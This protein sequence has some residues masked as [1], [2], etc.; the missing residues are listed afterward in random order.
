MKKSIYISSLLALFAAPVFAQDIH[1]SQFYMSPLTLNPAMAGAQ[2]EIQTLFNYKS[3][4]QSVTNPYKTLGFSYDMR[5][6]RKK[7]EK[8]II[9]AGINFFSDRAGDGKMGTTQANLSLS[10]HARLNS[11]NLLGGGLQAGYFQRSL[12]FSALY[13][14]SQYDGTSFNTSY[15]S[16]EP[17]NG[18]SNFS[19]PDF[20]AGIAWTYDN[21]A[22]SNSVTGDN[23]LKFNLGLSAMHVNQPGY[24]FYQAEG[25][26]PMKYTVHGTGLI[27]MKNSNLAFVPGFMYMKQGDAQE[28]YAGTLLRYTMGMDSKYTGFKNGAALSLGGFMRAKDALSAVVMFEYANYSMG[29]SYDIN[30]SG[31]TAAS[32]GRGGIEIALR[33]ISPNPFL[34]KKSV[35][36]FN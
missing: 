30:T 23:D 34:G 27:G 36:S 15:I 31:L 33:F 24:S 35:S 1:F 22:N 7:D 10:Y 28:I 32:N 25:K 21:S 11:D 26:L 8:G 16:G 6:N 3:Q 17:V 9:A 18:T 2:H 5:L 29:F 20:G 4:W 12:N 13:W 19:A 14:G